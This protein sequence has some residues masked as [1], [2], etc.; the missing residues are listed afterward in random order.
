MAPQTW[1]ETDCVRPPLPGEDWGTDWGSA[2]GLWRLACE[3]VHRKQPT[4]RHVGF[5]W[6]LHG[7][8]RR[9]GDLV[10][11]CVGDLDRMPHPS[12]VRAPRGSVCL[13]ELLWN[14]LVLFA[15]AS[16]H[17]VGECDFPF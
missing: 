9:W 3:P 8:S 15:S 5:F 11:V 13:A 12:Y 14:R 10:S 17:R 7:V 2:T 1:V 16:Q 6:L 4:E